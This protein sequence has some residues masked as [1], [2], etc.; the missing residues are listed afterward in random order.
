MNKFIKKKFW[1]IVPKQYY[2]ASKYYYQFFNNTLNKEMLYV[3]KI[4]KK[5]RRFIDIGS[6]IGIFSYHFSRFMENVESFEP[7]NYVSHFIE[8]SKIKNIK[9]YKI[10]LSDKYG[11][12][13]INVPFSDNNKPLYSRSSLN[14]IYKNKTEHKVSMKTLDSY[15][16]KNVDV[17]KIDVEGHEDKVIRGSLNTI[18]LYKPIILVEIEERFSNIGFVNQV[19]IIKEMGYKGFFLQ[20]NKLITIDK[21]PLDRYQST[22]NIE[23][24]YKYIN[25]F[26]FIPI[27]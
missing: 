8:D 19:R 25:N 26:I 3:S 11:K 6:N 27:T 22:D 4:L 23:I 9:L 21:F 24:N 1:K 16:F 20:N 18:N 15:N 2:L 10:A 17:I 14:K 13:T 7:I 12:G 5:K